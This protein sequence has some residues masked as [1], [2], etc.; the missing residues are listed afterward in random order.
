M[1]Y[2][3][4]EVD[5][6]IWNMITWGTVAKSSAYLGYKCPEWDGLIIGNVESL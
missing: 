1:K 6:S 4:Q 3:S 5:K 2:E